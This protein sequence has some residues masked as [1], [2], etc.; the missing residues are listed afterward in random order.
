LWRTLVTG[1]WLNHCDRGMAV[2]RNLLDISGI[3]ADVDEPK[4]VQESIAFSNDQDFVALLEESNSFP[5][6][7][8]R[9]VAEKLSGHLH[10]RWWRRHLRPDGR[11]LSPNL[12]R[13][14]WRNRGRAVIENVSVCAG[15][16]FFQDLEQIQSELRFLHTERRE[17]P[18]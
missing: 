16:I 1:W 10:R 15:I 14:F 5:G 9:G 6:A 12:F 17:T 2:V 13:R 11:A 3:I 4:I 8:R 7:R 18:I